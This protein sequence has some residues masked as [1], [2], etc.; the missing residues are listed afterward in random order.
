MNNDFADQQAEIRRQLTP[1]L[2]VAECRNVLGCSREHVLKLIGEQRLEAFDIAGDR[3]YD[4]DF[5]GRGIRVTPN[6]LQQFLES[7]RQ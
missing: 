7:A 1:L 2:S 6:S 4:G 3:I 5:A